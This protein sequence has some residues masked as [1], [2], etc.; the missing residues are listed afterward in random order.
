MAELYPAVFY[1]SIF[2]YFSSYLQVVQYQNITNAGYI[3]STFTLA[4]TAS[5]IVVGLLIRYTKRYKWYMVGGACV[6]LM[7]IGIMIRYR[8]EG[9]NIGSIVGSQIVIGIGGGFFNV[10]AQLGVQASVSHQ[11]VAA[12]TAIFL[13]VIEI[14]GAVGAAISGAVWTSNLSS[15]LASYLPPETQSQAL[16]IAGNFTLAQAFLPGTPERIAINQAYQETM[17]ILLIIA[18]CLAAPIIPLS[19]LM[20]DY[21][22]DDVSCGMVLSE[23]EADSCKSSTSQSRASSL[24]TANWA[25]GLPRLPRSLSLS[26]RT[27]SRA[28]SAALARKPVSEVLSTT[29]P[30]S[31][32]RVDVV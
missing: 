27:R 1:T 25:K 6:Y 26:G 9:S 8:V 3:V 10:P 29:K 28:F 19:F 23:K 13:T 14:G 22:L 18:I 5:S 20:K 17:N 7:G 31:P 24:E 30:S 4:S 11:D 32:D 21:K 15:K 12:A 2:P 16:F